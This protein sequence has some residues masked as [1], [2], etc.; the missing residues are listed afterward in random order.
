MALATTVVAPE[1]AWEQLDD[2]DLVDTKLILVLILD[3]LTS[4]SLIFG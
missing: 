3:E 4:L 1:A 2:R